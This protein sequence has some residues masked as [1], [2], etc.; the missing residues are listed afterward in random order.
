MLEAYAVLRHLRRY[1]TIFAMSSGA[2]PA[3]ISVIRVS[4]KESRRCL[5]ELT[6]RE[7]ILPRELFYANIRRDG[8]LI[9]RGMAV[10]L[11]GPK[12][13]T[14]EDVAEFYVHGSRAVVDCLLEALAQ[15]DNVQPAKAG[16]FTKRAFFNG[17]MTLHEVQSLAYLLAARTQHEALGNIRK[18]IIE[19]R[20]SVEASIDFG[21]DVEFQWE[22]I[23][24]AMSSIISELSCIQEQMKRGA[25]INEG[26]RIVILGQTNVG[27]SS[28]FN[29]MAN[30]DMAIVSNIEGTTRDS[31]E[32]TVQLSSVPVTII[33]TAG[34]RE[35]P[36]DSLEAEG[37]QRTL[38][39]AVEADIIIVV[40]DS[41]ICKDFERDVRSVLS[42]CNLKKDTPVFVA[43][44]K[45]DLRSVPNNI[46]L[47]WPAISI[48][49]ISGEGI[50]SLL[51]IICDYIDELCPISDNSALVSSQIHRL[52]VKEAISVLTKALK[53]KDVAITAELLRDVSDCISEMSGIVVNEQ[54]L[55]E[56]FSSFCIGK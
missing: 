35:I 22:D 16:E 23:R 6:G 44:N 56:I 27:K 26:L 53:A 49:C 38:R 21:D 42:W 36:L 50:S 7:K 24:V 17:K 43:L 32:I 51:K 46:L 33:D 13:S 52:L 39:R 18:Q 48:S 9:D 1:S 41:S 55:D 54:I 11:P 29:H 14:G 31:L 25:L 2:L 45:C 30:R 12:T 15:F 8:E 37:I 20:A 40:L 47:P 28:L 5:E 4:G 34:I 19:V 3:A 10:F